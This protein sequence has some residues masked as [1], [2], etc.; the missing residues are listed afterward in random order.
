MSRHVR[1]IGG[2]YKRSVLP[3]LDVEGLRPTPDRVRETLFNWLGPT[4]AGQHCLDMFAGSGALGFEAA[5]RGAARVLMIEQHPRVAQQLR[6]NQQ[7][8][9]AQAVQ[10]V[11]A[12]ALR[13]VAGLPPRSFDLILLDPPFGSDLLARALAPCLSLATVTGAIYIEAQAPLA[14]LL[15][16]RDEDVAARNGVKFPSLGQWQIDRAARAGAV[17]Y[18]LLRCDSSHPSHSS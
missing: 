9:D 1:I 6:A 12:D 3:V 8:L 10:V 18:H 14:W 5:S 7:K 17:H 15:E 4:L 11:R 13:F 2:T 16:N